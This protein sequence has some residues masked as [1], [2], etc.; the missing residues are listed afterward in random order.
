MIGGRI[1][2]VLPYVADDPHFCLTYGDGVADVDILAGIALHKREGRMATVTA[3]QPPGRFGALRFD[4]E[5]VL[6]FQEK[7]QGDGG[8]INGGF[9]VLSPAVG[10]YIEGDQTVWEQEPLEKL[11]T[12]GQLSVYFHH[13]FWQPMDTLRD[14]NHLEHLWQNG[15]ASWKVW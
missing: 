9:F 13:G 10:D 5:K 15:K 1:E 6:G 2:R 12:D 7:P 3:I 4:G 8:W 11:A 14:R